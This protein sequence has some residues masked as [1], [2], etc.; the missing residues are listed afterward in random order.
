MERY[1]I[2]AVSVSHNIQIVKLYVFLGSS[3]IRILYISFEIASQLFERS[4]EDFAVIHKSRVPLGNTFGNRGKETLPL[5]H[6]SI[7]Y[8][9]RINYFSHSFIVHELFPCILL[10]NFFERL[11]NFS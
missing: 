1:L 11:L 2:L 5:N 10:Q 6:D 4:I 7:L 9:E 3:Y 8:F